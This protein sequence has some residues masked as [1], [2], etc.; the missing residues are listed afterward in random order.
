M[1]YTR[2]VCATAVAVIVI[3]G[4]ALGQTESAT[5]TGKVTDTSSAAVTGAD[6][7]LRSVERGTNQVVTT[8]G[9]G[10]YEFSSVQPGQYRM[11]VRHAGF[12]EI[13]LLS[14]IVNVQD[15]LEENFRLQVGS[16]SESVTVSGSS[17]LVNTESATV[18]TVIDRNFAENLPMNGRSFQT[19]IYLTPGVVPVAIGNSGYDS[20]QFSVN[21]QRAASNYWM[22]DGVS[23]NVGSSTS[24]QGQQIA[25]AVGTSSVLGGTNSLVSV[26]AMQEFRI[27]TS[28]F[29][30]EYGRTPGAQI[31]I[32]TRSGSNALHGSAF[33]Y[34][35]NDLLDANNW[36]NGYV[37]NP[38]LPKARERQNDFG[39]TL[40][41][42]V[43]RNKTFF[44]FSY[45]GTR[46]RLPTTALSTVPSASARQSA[47]PA[48]RPYLNAYP[49]DPSQPDLGDGTAQFNSSYSDP[50]TLDDY[51][52]RIDHR[53]TDKL[54]LFG[55]YNNSPSMISQRGIGFNSLSTVDVNR[56]AAQQLTIGSSWMLSSRV[57]NEV[58]FNYST[59]TASGGSRLD[60]FGGAS[61]LQSLP[62]PNPFNASN[63]SWGLVIGSLQHAD[64][65]E[66]ILARNEQRQFNLVDNLT[67]QMGAH[68]VKVG[69][70][71]RRLTPV[72]D[73][74]K[75]LQNVF[76]SDIPSA[77]GGAL[78]GKFLASQV[79][80]TF[81]FQNISLFAQDTWKIGPRLV[82]TYGLR[83]D[84]DL[85]PSTI[86]GPTLLALTG[87]SGLGDLSQLAF[88]P[89]GRPL[90]KTS[91]GNIAPRIGAAY[92]LSQRQ[93][94]QTVARGGFGVFYDLASSE[95]A[96]LVSNTGYPF[97][98]GFNFVSGGTFPLFPQ[99]AAP[100]PIVPPSVTNPENISGF[101]PNLKLP[102]TLGW[103][104]AVEQGLGSK[105]RLTLTYV[106]ASG[107]RL[108]QSVGVVA[109]NAIT[110]Q[111]FLSLNGGVSDYNALQAQ[112]ERRLARNLQILASYTW[113]HSLDNGSAGSAGTGS[114]I[115][116]STQNLGNR[117]PSDFDLRHVFS[118]GV[119][120]SIP[121]ITHGKGIN[122][123][124]SGWSLQSILQ[125]QSARPV[126]IQ[127]GNFFRLTNGFNPDIRPDI[128]P[129]IPLYLYGTQFP[130]GRAINNTPGAVPGGC[131]NGSPSVGPFCDPPVDANF[132]AI[133]QGTLGR[134][135]VRGFGLFQWDLG[136]HRDFA[137][138]ES[139]KLEFRAEMF[140]FLN[141]PNFAPP[142]GDIT[143][144]DFGRSTEMLG[145]QLSGGSLGAGGFSSLYQIGG[146]RSMQMA[147]KLT[148]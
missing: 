133:R 99:A 105:Q 2:L 1:S 144:P 96:N 21:G 23:G 29:A 72:R 57:M 91:W 135:V 62:L 114:N 49:L 5:I 69:M 65:G 70:D 63:A 41:G 134:N 102:Y 110:S 19:L 81:L 101:D 16:V 109:P 145:Q 113:S 6:V 59:T 80:A 123:V 44:F 55:R 122:H 111:A 34:L 26:D 53:L 107:R 127:D 60:S 115:P 143:S 93:D 76:F 120:Y 58:R 67:A 42:P 138:S 118:T 64:L 146:P 77:D 38:A 9:A 95:T 48:M 117:G 73:P 137:I 37:N 121:G 112:F 13:D 39:G 84:T 47:I 140:N 97:V 79:G 8:N 90:F 86:S 14:F 36:F 66:G 129:G 108:I 125:A 88:A 87:F 31:S 10:I 61:P 71:Y 25:G 142:V 3:A 68:D 28:S 54:T 50:A 27:Q 94:W 128:T 130:G 30:P 32:V 74:N 85:P 148:F 98:G 116:S 139:V 75:Y 45:E 24:N 35:R 82:L 15:R 131:P 106:G 83:W 18:S 119:T 78:F 89:A 56:I 104:V 40:S 11:V 22:V 7:E 43:L 132:N 20:G 51:S 46:L 12:R 136:V 147:L 103:N 141:H 33:D 100:P 92:Q 4:M 52:I 124:T 126:P 17:A